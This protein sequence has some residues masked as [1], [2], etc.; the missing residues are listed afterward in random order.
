MTPA[1]RVQAAIDVLDA[2]LEGAPAE[3]TLTNWARRSRFAGSG[4]RAAIRDLVFGALR[5]RRSFGWLGGGDTGRGVMIGA[6]R[7][8][9]VDPKTIFTGEG[10]A[11]LLLSEA[12]PDFVAAGEPELPVAF[13]VPDWLIE[14]LG[15]S[16][17]A[18]LKGILDIMR[19]RA[20]V[21]LRINLRKCTRNEAIARLLDEG[22]ETQAHPLSATALKVLSNPRK[23]RR[24]NAFL[25]GLI[26]LQDA[27]SQAVVD[28]LDIGK[29]ARVLDYCAGGGGKALAIAARTD[30]QVF[31]HDADPVRMRDISVRAARSGA[32]ITELEAGQLKGTGP[33]D[34]VFC[35]APCSGSGAWRRSPEAKWRLTPDRLAELCALQADILKAGADLV[36]VDGILAY[37][38]CSLLENE[39]SA[40]VQEFLKQDQRFELIGDRRLTPLDGG[41]GFYVAQMRRLTD[42]L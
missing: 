32:F 17:G 23:V 22:I 33:F 36:V 24:S 21:F 37:A 11:P 38:T 39:N 15:L 42:H 28:T 19:A 14:P 10:Y 1:A 3:K 35:D 12:E 40:Q 8:E 2:V 30:A 4:D 16:L 34:L 7:S 26:E 9:G 27:A 41:D 6:L 13:D 29:D 20:P 18:D 5:C 31:A 25:D